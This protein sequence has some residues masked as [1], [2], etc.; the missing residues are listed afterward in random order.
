MKEGG[1]H[2]HIPN[3]VFI[4]NA[5]KWSSKRDL[6]RDPI[7]ILLSFISAPDHLAKTTMKTIATPL[8]T[9]CALLLLHFLVFSSS[10][11]FP[12]MKTIEEISH[13]RRLLKPLKVLKVEDN[14]KM[15]EK[16]VSESMRR[17]PSSKSN[18][19]QN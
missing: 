6:I 11:S 17:V 18:P 7:T 8:F 4:E 15:N 5:L 12:E 3:L 13:P 10:S 9:L 16:M 19:I 1:Q 14:V 2:L